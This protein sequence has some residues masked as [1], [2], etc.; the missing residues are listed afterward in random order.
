M[1]ENE[2]VIAYEAEFDFLTS[3]CCIQEFRR[4]RNFQLY[5]EKDFLKIVLPKLNIFS[6]LCCSEIR[7]NPWQLDKIYLKNARVKRLR[8]IKR[9]PFGALEEKTT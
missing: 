7:K 3:F 2:S 5:F 1:L 9:A 4:R 6:G 8:D